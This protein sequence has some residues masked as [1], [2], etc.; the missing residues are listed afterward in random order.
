MERGSAAVTSAEWL[1]DILEST[2]SFV[3]VALWRSGI[4]LETAG[5]VGAALAA[6]VLIGFRAYKVRFNPILLGINTHLLLI[7]PLVVALFHFG[8][9]GLGKILVA[10][11]YKGVLITIFLIGCALTL[12]SREGFIGFEK[13]SRPSV[14][15]YSIVLLLASLAAIAWA[16]SYSGGAVVGIVLPIVALFGL[17]R[18]LIARWLDNNRQLS[19]FASAACGA[20][21]SFNSG[22][23]S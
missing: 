9:S 5:W 3:L 23:D 10:H 21:L 16:F 8:A 17:R 12:L 11:S 1:T 6:A 14:V 4:D 13:L 22:S 15:T 19:V 2:P 20:T 7:T 18:L